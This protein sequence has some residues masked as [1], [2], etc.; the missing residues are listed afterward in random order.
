[1]AAI[2]REV[3]KDLKNIAGLAARQSAS[4]PY[5]RENSEGE[6]RQSAIAWNLRNSLNSIFLRNAKDIRII[7][8]ANVGH[9]TVTRARLQHQFRGKDMCL[10]QSFVLRFRPASAWA[11]RTTIRDSRKW[12]GLKLDVIHIAVS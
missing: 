4:R 10:T 11:R 8:Y 2:N 1:M 9:A 6:C 7:L 3:F 12:A 5:A